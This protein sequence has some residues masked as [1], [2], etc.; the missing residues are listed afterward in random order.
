MVV[1]SVSRWLTARGRCHVPLSV[2]F[3]PPVTGRASLTQVSGLSV[4][5]I[6][7]HI[8]RVHIHITPLRVSSPLWH[9]PLAAKEN[10]IRDMNPL[11]VY[12]NSISV[13]NAGLNN[14]AAGLV[15]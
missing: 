9:F 10:N 11:T 12:I 13:T 6:R 3:G 14:E 15:I 4:A 1:V 2:L 5:I 8:I 7:V